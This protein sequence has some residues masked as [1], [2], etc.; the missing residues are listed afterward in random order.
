M[1]G[2]FTGT[3]TF[4][5]TIKPTTKTSANVIVGDTFNIGAKSNAKITNLLNFII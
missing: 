1:Q 3:K 4:T 5:F 2:N